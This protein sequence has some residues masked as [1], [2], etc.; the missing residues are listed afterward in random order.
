MTLK[1]AL[2]AGEVPK[3]ERT[4]AMTQLVTMW[5]G[6]K[7]DS[8]YWKYS[9]YLTEPDTILQFRPR[10]KEVLAVIIYDFRITASQGGYL[11]L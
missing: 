2:L 4:P 10:L 11:Q 3:S 8:S 5:L 1:E 9:F 6:S 7:V